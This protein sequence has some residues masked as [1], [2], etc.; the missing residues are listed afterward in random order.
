MRKVV[1]LGNCQARRLEV[2][3]AS[4]FAPANN[5]IVTFYASYEE[6]TDE[7]R[8]GLAD[9]DVIVA[10]VID[11]EHKISL[12]KVETEADVLL[13]PNIMGVFLW[14]YSGVPHPYNKPLKYHIAGP[15]GPELG[16]RFLNSRLKEGADPAAILAEYEKLDIAKK[17]HVGR[18]YELVMERQR[19]RDEKTGFSCAEIIDQHIRDEPLFL[20]PMQFELKLFSHLAQ[21]VYRKLGIATKH[22]GRALGGQWRS[23]FP[24]VSQPIHP[25]IIA[26]FRLRYVNPES[27]YRYYTGEMLTFR[28]HV[29]R[30]LRYDFNEPLLEGV[31]QVHQ[32]SQSPARRNQLRALLDKGLARAPAPTAAGQAALSHIMGLAGE[33]LAA[34]AAMQ[35]AAHLAPHDP[36]LQATIA[37]MVMEDGNVDEAEKLLRSMLTVWPKVAE[38]W[39]RLAVLLSRMSRFDEALDCARQAS[40]LSPFRAQL[41]VHLAEL[42]TRVNHYEEAEI[43]YRRGITMRPQQAKV[44]IS[45]A[46]LLTRLGENERAI[47]TV[48]DATKLEPSNLQYQGH[49]AHLY[50]R[51]DQ[52]NKAENLFSEIVRRNPSL[53]N[54]QV[55][56]AHVLERKGNTDGA[57][58]AVQQALKNDQNNSTYKEYLQKLLAQKPPA[59][60]L[61]LAYPYHAETF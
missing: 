60:S 23:P 44:L 52:L 8:K 5:D 33:K 47:S 22:I 26:H 24:Q 27:R 12:S 45:Y 48:R 3:Y 49:L 35:K 46:I 43:T 31:T 6:L 10:Q 61:Y 14:P 40:S 42:L 17:M 1:F 32:A 16:D 39:H 56:Y 21:G 59:A 51:N 38:I 58:A 37:S 57:I 9:A 7:V 20:T 15:F 11:S 55:G 19:Q 29:E 25:S 30:Y 13:F 54:I 53:P 36:N 18:M 41:V 2:L 34:R 28:Q 4:E 50:A